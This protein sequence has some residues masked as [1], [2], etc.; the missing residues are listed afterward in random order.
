MRILLTRLVAVV[1]AATL[2]LG[3]RVAL[4]DTPCDAAVPLTQGTL[5]PCTGLLLP[6]TQA[7]QA[8]IGLTVDLPKLHITLDKL[9][10]E[11][12]V[13]LESLQE[14]I[15]V[16]KTR[17]DSL[18]ALL[19]EAVAIPNQALAWYESPY[20]LVPVGIVVGSALTFGAVYAASEL[21]K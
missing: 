14:L 13:R 21:G 8:L 15:K 5:A 4:A 11:H 1:L 20:F 3:S 9:Q 2:T 18:K 19:D 6:E 10:L 12:S 17:A 7:R 16:E